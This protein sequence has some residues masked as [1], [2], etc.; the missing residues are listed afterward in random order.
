[1]SERIKSRITHHPSQPIIFNLNAIRRGKKH[2]S[3]LE[4]DIGGPNLGAFG[5]VFVRVRGRI[6]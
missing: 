4:S 1:M 3:I 5:H 6:D 2:T